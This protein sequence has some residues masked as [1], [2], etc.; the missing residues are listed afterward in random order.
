M[1][2]SAP[3]PRGDVPTGGRA[4][5]GNYANLHG[6]SGV[7]AY[8]FTET[9]II[10]TFTT[11]ATYLY[12]VE[13]TGSQDIINEMISKASDG[14]MLQRYINKNKPGYASKDN[15]PHRT[16]IPAGSPGTIPQSTF[17]KNPFG[18]FK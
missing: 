7:A 8:S 4:G 9:S 11:G 12:T 15:A 17:G 2:E 10:V 16:Y 13:S 6:N 14:V 1:A 5:T 3:I 18:G